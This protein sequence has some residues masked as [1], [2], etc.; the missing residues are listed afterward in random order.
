MPGM[1]P[2]FTVEVTSLQRNLLKQ[3]KHRR[4]LAQCLVWR[5][6]IILLLAKGFAITTVARFTGKN[7]NTVRLWGKRWVEAFPQ[8]QSA[9]TEGATST[10]GRKSLTTL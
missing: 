3:L 5:I 2:Y 9:K 7:R 4:K 8:L 10:R 1:Q 6:R